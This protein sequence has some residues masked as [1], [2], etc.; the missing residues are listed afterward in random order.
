M[1]A[2]NIYLKTFLSFLILTTYVQAEPEWV[3]EAQKYIQKEIKEQGIPG[4]SVACS[5]KGKIVFEKA[6]GFSDVENDIPARVKTLYRTASIAKPM[7]AIVVLSLF[8]SGKLDLDEAVQAYVKDFPQKKWKLTSRHLLGHLG[9]IRHYKSRAEATT[10]QHFQTIKEGLSLFSEEPLLHEP[11]TQFQYTTFGYN[12]LGVV[13]EEVSGKSFEKLLEEII[14]KP[15]GMTSST[16][17]NHYKIIKNR[18]RGYFR[19]KFS[20]D[21]EDN[22]LLFNAPLHDTSMKIPGGGLLSTPKDLVLMG[23]TVATNKLLKPETVK[24][25]GTKGKTKE[26]KETS[27]GLGWRVDKEYEQQTLAHS[28]GQAGTSTYMKVLMK[29]DIAVSV[30]CNLQGAKIKKLVRKVLDL[31]KGQ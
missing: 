11:G 23:H 19:I 31:I 7:T 26:G 10:T 2:S 12:L 13:A 6:Y 15:A 4:L 25:M 5:I 29:D 1:K 20:S 24:L 9:G 3:K 16:I 17:D 30:M 18:T 21:P 27:Y 22:G 28:G 8:E 14:F